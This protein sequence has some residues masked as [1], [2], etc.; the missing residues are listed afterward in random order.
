MEVESII[1]DFTLNR[2]V[3][4]QQVLANECTSAHGGQTATTVRN[5]SRTI[6]GKKFGHQQIATACSSLCVDYI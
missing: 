6:S 4:L 1:N 5:F 2:R 3:L